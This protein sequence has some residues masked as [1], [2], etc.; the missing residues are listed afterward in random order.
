MDAAS[1][2]LIATGWLVVSWMV[3]LA[4]GGFLR[5]GMATRSD[6]GDLIPSDVMTPGRILRTLRD[7][8]SGTQTARNPRPLRPGSKH[9]STRPT[10]VRRRPGPDYLPT[11][12]TAPKRPPVRH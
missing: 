5:S 1:I 6:N 4:L 7:Q 8:G 10:S 12:E 9:R 11:T 3:S 2:G